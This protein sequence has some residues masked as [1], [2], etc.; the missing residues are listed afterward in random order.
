MRI[1]YEE[2]RAAYEGLKA[3]GLA[4]DMTRGKPSPEQLDLANALLA[5]PGEGG[6]AY[7]VDGVDARNYGGL[8]GLPA[9]KGLFGD[10][11]G[12]APQNVIVGGNSSLAMMYDAVARA[13]LFGVVDEGGDLLPAWQGAVRKFICP[14]PGYDRHFAIT[15]QLGFELLAVEMGEGGPDMAEVEA[16]VADDVAVK[17]IWCVPKYSN[18]TGVCY[19]EE[20]VRRLAEMRCA[21]GDFRIFWDNAYAEHHF[22]DGGLSAPLANIAEACAKA[23]NANR[24]LQFASTSKISHAGSG[25]AAFAASEANV[26]DAKR[27]LGVQTIGPD[28]VNQ[29]RHLRLFGGRGGDLLVGLR[30]HMKQH[31]RLL[32]PKFDAVQEILT[33][34][35]GGYGEVARWSVPRGGYF[36]SLDTADGLAT[37]AVE[38]AE[39]IGVKLTAAGAPFPYGVDPRD[40][41]IRIAPSFP[42]LAEVEQAAEAVAVCVKLAAAERAKK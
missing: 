17:G 30:A 26:A 19:D 11:L 24:V 28:K 9:M 25:V 23:G 8:D 7:R 42:P 16:L 3:R 12:V 2:I 14:S 34:E 33:R 35:L 32:K 6:D 38:L 31:A 13:C 41:N 29:L 15:E 5:L 27:R 40:C 21:A 18:P 22:D 10:I 1:D 20:T 37:R 4:L 36:V 39:Q